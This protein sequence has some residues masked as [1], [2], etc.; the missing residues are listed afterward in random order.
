MA[1]TNY[2]AAIALIDEAHAHDPKI[3]IVDGKDVPYELHYARKM[4][5]YLSLR[6]P[7]ASPVLK[8]AIRAQHFRRWE[9]LRGS[10]PM[11]KAGYL[12]WRTFLKKRQAELAVAICMGCNFTTEEADEVAKLIRKE[13]LRNNEETQIL[14]DVACLVFLDDQFEAFEKEHDES[15]IIM[16]LR[17]TWGKMSEKGHELALQI[18]MSQSSKELVR[19]ALAE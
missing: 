18:P 4:T 2:E 19:K 11:T 1:A 8:V 10:Y 3:S 17:K 14:E 16:I 12:S 9:I 6:A 5:H 7:D 15:K 13:D